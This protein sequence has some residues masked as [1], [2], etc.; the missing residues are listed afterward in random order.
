MKSR[1]KL[2]NKLLIEKFINS[3]CKQK[4]WNPKNLSPSQL[5]EIV[6]Q[7]EYKMPKVYH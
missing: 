2:D 5:I 7:K 1:K 4:G 6:E 3:Y